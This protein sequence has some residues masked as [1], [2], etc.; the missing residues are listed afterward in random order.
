[1]YD[2]VGD[3]DVLEPL[4]IVRDAA[5]A[6]VVVLSKIQ[7]LA[8]DLRSRGA[9]GAARRAGLIA[10][11]DAVHL[12]SFLSVVK[13]ASRRGKVPARLFGRRCAGARRGHS[14]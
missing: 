14:L 3:R 8:D 9:R 11:A 1:M 5:V 6:E 2:G 13:G 12:K 7:N 4:Q 10:Q